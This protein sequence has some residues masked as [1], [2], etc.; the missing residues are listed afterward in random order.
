MI[1]K[2]S[3][4]YFT[5]AGLTALVQKMVI[6][7]NSKLAE[8]QM[9]T[10]ILARLQ[11]EIDAA[12]QAIGS[13][14]KQPLTQKVTQADVRRDNS[15]AS[16]RN[17]IKAGLRRENENYR[18]ACEALWAV[19]EKNGLKIDAMARNKETAALNS[20]LND[21]AKPEYEA[22]IKTVKITSWIDEVDA[23][24]KAFVAQSTQRSAARSTD[25][26]L[27]DA[28]AFKAL[29]VSLEILDNMLNTLQAMNTPEGIDQIVA[30]L[31]QYINE[32]NTAAKQGGSKTVQN[33]EELP[34]SEED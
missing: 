11:P 21:L 12:L 23:D 13:S 25:N 28:D 27:R 30:E 5:L 8:N 14:E 20:L 1:S 15:F 4:S 2:I 6:L 18:T 10:T 32:A 16:L 3:Y 34:V 22:Y 7:L 17:H 31:S 24:N 9:V 33:E 26:T 19:F 29:K